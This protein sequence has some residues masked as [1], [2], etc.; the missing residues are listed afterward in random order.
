MMKIFDLD[1]FADVHVLRSPDTKKVVL[2]KMSLCLSVCLSVCDHD[3]GQTAGDI[4]S[5]FCI[6][7]YNL[8]LANWLDFEQNR[9]TGS[10]SLLQWKNRNLQIFRQLLSLN[11]FIKNSYV[12]RIKFETNCLKKVFRNSYRK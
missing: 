4:N 1:I 9:Q 10:S 7:E 12:L 8:P 2:K 5:K 6:Y 3:S 11:K